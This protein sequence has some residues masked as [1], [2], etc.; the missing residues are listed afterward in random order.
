MKIII[1]EEQKELL[2]LVRRIKSPEFHNLMEEIIIEGF[3]YEDVC[4]KENFYDYLESILESSVPT[5]INSFSELY[6]LP[7]FNKVGEFIYKY[8]EQEFEELIFKR[9]M[10]E[11]DLCNED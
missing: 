3:D 8:M 7:S 6:G 2:W 1:T 9:Y 10:W 5:F 11:E 4:T